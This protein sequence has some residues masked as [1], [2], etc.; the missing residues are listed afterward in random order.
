LGVARPGPYRRPGLSPLSRRCVRLDLQFR[1]GEGGHVGEHRRA[2]RSGSVDAFPTG[3]E[4][5]QPRTP[6]PQ[7]H[8][9]GQHVLRCP[10]MPAEDLCNAV[11]P[12]WF[13]YQP[14]IVSVMPVA[15][16]HRLSCGPHHGCGCIPPPGTGARKRIPVEQGL[17][18]Q[19]TEAPA[20]PVN[21]PARRDCRSNGVRGVSMVSG[22]PPPA[23]GQR[24]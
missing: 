3:D 11:R 21:A 8:G 24:R 7:L 5:P 4:H 14:G 17:A 20:V 23:S 10:T 18:G 12:S 1:L 16:A 15:S 2:P 19:S 6:V 13:L 22:S 9:E